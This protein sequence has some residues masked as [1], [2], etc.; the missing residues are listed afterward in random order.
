VSILLTDAATGDAVGLDYRGETSQAADGRGNI[1]QAKLAIPAGTS[2]PTSIRAYAIA[3]VF[4]LG[5]SVF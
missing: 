5:S 4:P 3:D 1:V 2:L